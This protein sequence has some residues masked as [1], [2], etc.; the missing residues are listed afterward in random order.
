MNYITLINSFWDSVTINPLS[1]GQVSLYMA[2]LHIYNRSSWT[3]WFTASNQVLS[4][5]T[6]LSRS[7]I[8][9][10]RNELKQKGLID[11]K[12]RGTRATVYKVVTMSDS[13]QDSVQDGTQKGNQV[14][15]QNSGTLYKQKQRQKNI[16]DAIQE[17][18]SD[19]ENLNEAVSAFVDYRKG[20]RAPMDVHAIGL[21]SKS[22]EEM[23]PGDNQTKIE[24]LNQSIMNGWKCILPL[25]KSVN[26]HSQTSSSK[27]QFHNFHQRDTDYD[28]MILEGL[29]KEQE[30]G[31]AEG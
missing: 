21:L 22:L 18:F 12:E 14:S 9:K 10:A 11:F 17:K 15:V 26:N 13:T 2:L 8:L 20:I 7:G 31:S 24:I 25:K 3:E 16:A 5:L 28:A 30:K 27:N 19:D 23:A 4:V 6:G 29:R 1:T